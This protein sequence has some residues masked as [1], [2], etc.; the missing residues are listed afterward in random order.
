M[1]SLTKM[2]NVLDLFTPEHPSWTIEEMAEHL[3]YAVPTMY[4]YAKEL[5]NAGLLRHSSGARYVL[6]TRIIELDYQIRNIDPLI[7]ASSQAM[8]SL[9]E[10]SG[11]DVV[12][13]TIYADRI[14]TVSHA[15]GEENLKISF[16]RGKRMPLFKGALSKCVLSTLS[17]PQLRKVMADNTGEFAGLEA[18]TIHEQLKEIRK[19]GYWATFSELNQGVVG[20]AIPYQNKQHQINASLGFIV[21]D[22]RYSLMEEDKAVAE[23]QNCAEEID[24]ALRHYG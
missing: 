1:S 20:I 11:S 6:G 15:F 2:L 13:G 10:K 23:L 24:F 14:I 19:K 7:Q 21:S 22:K 17:K 18:Q 5:N 8:R 3:G 16:V 12:L 9:A 4:R